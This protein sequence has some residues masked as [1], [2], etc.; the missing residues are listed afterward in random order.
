MGWQIMREGVV[1]Y[2]RWAFFEFDT[3]ELLME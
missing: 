3:L 2:I 1:G